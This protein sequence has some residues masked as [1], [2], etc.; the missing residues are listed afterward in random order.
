MKSKKKAMSP[1]AR[2]DNKTVVAGQ[3]PV[4]RPQSSE[5]KSETKAASKEEKAAPIT[6]TDIELSNQNQGSRQFRQ[7]QIDGQTPVIRSV[8]I[9]SIESLPQV[10]KHFDQEELEEL[11]ESIKEFG[12]LQPITVVPKPF[13][14]NYIVLMGERR[15]R[16]ARLLMAEDPS[17]NTIMAI[18]RSVKG[19]NDETDMAEWSP[20]ARG[21]WTSVQLMENMK[22]TDLTA[23]EMAE[24]LK[25]LSDI[26]LTHEQISARLGKSRSWVTQ[27]MGIANRCPEEIYQYAVDKQIK[28]CYLLYSLIRLWSKNEAGCRSLLQ[29]ETITNTM[30]KR[31]ESGDL[32]EPS[33]TSTIVS[34][35]VGPLPENAEIVPAEEQPDVSNVTLAAEGGTAAAIED[36]EH[37]SDE[38]PEAPQITNVNK[39][40]DH[41]PKQPVRRYVYVVR[42]KNR[43]VR[44]EKEYMLDMN[45]KMITGDGMVALRPLHSGPERRV[46][47]VQDIEL[48]GA[49]FIHSTPIFSSEED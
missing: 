42:L 8:P 7:D 35:E 24:S 45:S 17:K 32:S 16:A 1:F 46:V 14:K 5:A 12:L 40:V 22:R 33:N 37:A 18:I 28:D 31:V 39:P 34:A 49:R 47:P 20:E 41:T 13:S 48:I 21:Y 25:Q 3:A 15:L 44:D 6:I 30:I 19:M 29:N 26:G 10:R 38:E 11:K 27:V 23:L 9:E 4:M 36:D 2:M 43:Q